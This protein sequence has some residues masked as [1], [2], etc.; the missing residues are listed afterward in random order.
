MASKTVWRTGIGVGLF[1]LTVLSASTA[2]PFIEISTSGIEVD[3]MQRQRHRGVEV[4]WV[5]RVHLI[6]LRCRHR[7]SASIFTI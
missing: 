5:R 3:G 4:D 2:E 1:V 6:R 7:T